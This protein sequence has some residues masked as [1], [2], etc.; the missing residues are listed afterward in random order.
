MSQA[1][2]LGVGAAI[3]EREIREWVQDECWSESRQSYV[4]YPGTEQL[5]ASIL[6]HAGSGFDTGPQM[7]ATI[8]ALGEELGDGPLRY[9]YSGAQQ[10]EGAFLA[11]IRHV[12]WQRVQDL[13]QPPRH[14]HARVERQ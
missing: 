3:E 6:L 2:P 9:R 7:S 8:D 4:W 10:D 11:E 12:G 5:D 14:P 1:Q 13:L